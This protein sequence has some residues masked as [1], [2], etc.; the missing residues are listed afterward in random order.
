MLELITVLDGVTD[1]ATAQAAAPRIAALTPQW[2]DQ[3]QAA[4][5][6]YLVLPDDQE[7]SAMQEAAQ[8]VQSRIEAAPE[9]RGG[10]NFIEQTQ[11]IAAAPYGA[12]LHDEL[13]ALR[14]AFL[15]TRGIYSPT[16][17]RQHVEEK[18]GPVGSPIK[19]N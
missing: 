2:K 1:E 10:R 17:A 14:D 5:A 16:R 7:G 9:R 18:L 15:T 8:Q 4:T 13:Q 3:A 6:A 12:S 11:R 19:T